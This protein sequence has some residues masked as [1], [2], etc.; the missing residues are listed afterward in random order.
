[1]TPHW[2]TTRTNCSPSPT[3]SPFAYAL[4]KGRSPDGPEIVVVEDDPEIRETLGD[5]LEEWG[6][7]VR[8]AE[9]GESGLAL[10]VEHPPSVALV[11][12]AMPRLDGYGLARAVRTAFG[13]RGPTLV[14][15]TSCGRQ[16]DRRRAFEAGFDVHLT[17]PARLAALRQV[18]H[19]Y[20]RLAAS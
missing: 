13:D 4:A 18:L 3:P 9:D 12:I 17:K 16:D 8:L 7:H 6:Y 1:M 15:L 5:L 2:P 10:I 11:D 19:E 14:A 20:T